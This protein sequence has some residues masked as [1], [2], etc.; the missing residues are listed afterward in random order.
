M[1]AFFLNATA[2]V[3]GKLTYQRDGRANSNTG[4][5]MIICRHGLHVLEDRAYVFDPYAHCIFL[6]VQHQQHI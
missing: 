1:R 6:E 4:G 3:G 2:T 5:L